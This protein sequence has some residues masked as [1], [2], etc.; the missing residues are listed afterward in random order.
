MLLGDG[1]KFFLRFGKCDVKTAF[2][3]LRTF[4]QVLKGEGGLARARITI[5]EI[6]A[7]GYETTVE[8]VIKSGDTSGRTGRSGHVRRPCVERVVPSARCPRKSRGA[9]AARAH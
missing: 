7:V 6:Q 1:G 5:Y 8:N 2:S 4:K 9:A 3:T